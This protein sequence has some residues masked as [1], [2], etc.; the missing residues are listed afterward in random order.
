MRD[1]AFA[2]VRIAS[3]GWGFLGLRGFLWF[4]KSDLPVL[5]GLYWI[6]P[7]IA[8]FTLALAPAQLWNGYFG[9]LALLGIALAGMAR[10][11]HVLANDLSAYGGPDLSA[12]LLQAVTVVLLLLLILAR[13]RPPLNAAAN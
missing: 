5:L 10:S 8:L 13:G 1:V 9:R 4:Y 12:A 7:V 3:I 6:A 11:I 2:L